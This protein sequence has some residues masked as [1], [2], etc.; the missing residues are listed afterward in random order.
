MM[1]LGTETD[2]NNVLTDKVSL[3]WRRTITGCS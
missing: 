1:N 2:E 3:E